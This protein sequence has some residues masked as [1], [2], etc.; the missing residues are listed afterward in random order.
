M[1]DIEKPTTYK[2]ILKL[3]IIQG[4]VTILFLFHEIMLQ[5]TE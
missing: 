1:Y 5:L 4:K 2:Y 3:N